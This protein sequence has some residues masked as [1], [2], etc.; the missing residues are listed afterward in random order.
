MWW[1]GSVGVRGVRYE[2]AW[3]GGNTGEGQC[4]R[5]TTSWLPAFQVPIRQFG[6]PCGLWPQK[7]LFI[8]HSINKDFLLYFV[9]NRSRVL[10]RAGRGQCQGR[11]TT[12]SKNQQWRWVLM[13]HE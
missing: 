1:S 12:A 2:L 13:D 11:T 10:Q 8:C 4:R 7:S 5:E 9:E 6:S 3:V